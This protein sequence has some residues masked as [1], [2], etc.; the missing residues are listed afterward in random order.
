MEKDPGEKAKRKMPADIDGLCIAF[1][2]SSTEHIYYLNLD[3]GEV[4]MKITD[5]INQD[6]EEEVRGKFDADNYLPVP[7]A[8]THEAYQDMEEFALSVKVVASL[9]LWIRCKA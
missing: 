9:M 6:E 2:D 8:D 3:T 7:S 5:Y 4:E 1:E